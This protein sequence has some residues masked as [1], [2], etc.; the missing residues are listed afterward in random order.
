MDRPTLIAELERDEANR[1]KPYP[2]SVGKLTIGIGRNLTDN[3]ITKEESYFLCNND[4]D[5]VEGD[6]DYNLPWW[7]NLNEVR[8]RVLANMCF[9]MG[10]VR[11]LKFSNMLRHARN[12]E[13]TLAAVEMRA[14]KW[15][16]QVGIRATRL[17]SMMRTGAINV[18][19][20]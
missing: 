8:Q 5:D 18:D 17:E 14:S 4:I 7:R 2:D 16:E 13:Y 10:I 3:G 15:Y 9:N 11:L 19:P 6:L 1:L 12:G 20:A